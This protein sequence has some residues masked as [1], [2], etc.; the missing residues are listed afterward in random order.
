MPRNKYPEETIEKIL[1][2]AKKLFLEKGYEQTT[3]LDI[4]GELGGLTRGAFYHHFKSKEEV[5]D[6]L[7]MRMFYSNNPFERAKEQ[8]H[9]NG[10]QKLQ[11]AIL[12]S[13]MSEYHD[14]AV[15]S[16]QALKSPTFLK[17][18]IDDNRIT[19]TPMFEELIEEGV[20]DGSIQTEHPK[21]LAELVVILTNFWMIPTIYPSTEAESMERLLYVRDIMEKLGL[22]L[23]DE[24]LLQKVLKDDGLEK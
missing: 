4:V 19:V 17:A 12:M 10:L 1:E 7:S 22:P 13:N 3:I 9:L 6:M 11:Y 20:K 15:E 23:L 16:L 18:L 5:L 8:K 14:L 2:A 24:E 21:L